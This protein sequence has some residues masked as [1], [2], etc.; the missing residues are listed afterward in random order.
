MIEQLAP[1]VLV[2]VSYTFTQPIDVPTAS[3]CAL[4]GS[5]LTEQ[6]ASLNDVCKKCSCSKSHT[7]AQNS[8]KFE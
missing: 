2:R 4:S 6:A 3:E 5:Q 8:L 7:I 1:E